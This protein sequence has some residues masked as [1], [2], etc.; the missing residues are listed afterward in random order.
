M[1]VSDLKKATKL[2]AQMEDLKSQLKKVISHANGEKTL[3]VIVF[4]D[5]NQEMDAYVTV[6]SVTSLLEND[7]ADLKERLEKF[8]AEF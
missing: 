7:I 2:F 1:K 3:K 4:P 6:E 5:T 8:G